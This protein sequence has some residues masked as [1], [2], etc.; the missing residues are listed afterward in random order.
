MTAFPSIC[1]AYE[2]PSHSLGVGRWA[3]PPPYL[4]PTEAAAQ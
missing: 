1:R 4:S 2:K 3:C